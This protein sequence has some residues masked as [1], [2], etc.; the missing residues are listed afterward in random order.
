[1]I[2]QKRNL[3]AKLW[4]QIYDQEVPT[5]TLREG[6]VYGE[7]YYAVECR[8]YIWPDLYDWCANSFGP[9]SK[10][11]VWEPGCRWYENNTAFWFKHQ[12]DR[13]WFVMRWS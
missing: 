12:K 4:S 8:G 13:D 7:P 5:L 2:Q 9:I 1:M 6:T 3:I 10:Q 11:G